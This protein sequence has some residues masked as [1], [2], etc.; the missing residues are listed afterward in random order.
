MRIG[1][2]H[3]A[4]EGILIVRQ[5]QVRVVAAFAG[6]LA[7]EYDGDVGSLCQARRC[8]RIGSAVILHVRMRRLGANG[9][10]RRG[11]VPDHAIEERRAGRL[12]HGIPAHRIDLGRSAARQDAH[13]GMRSDDRNGLHARHCQGQ[14]RVRIL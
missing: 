2:G 3:R 4:Y 13:I 7:D 12:Q 14:L 10:Q 6:M 5:R 11:A 8:C 1:R 9:L